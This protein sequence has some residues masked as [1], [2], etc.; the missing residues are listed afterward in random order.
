MRNDPL[1]ALPANLA[2]RRLSMRVALP[3]GP[4][5]RIG[6]VL[7][8]DAERLTLERRTG[9]VET[10]ERSR[11]HLA[12]LVPTVPRGRNPRHAPADQLSDLAHDPSLDAF[13]GPCW[14]ARL[15]DLVD[16][17]DDSG[18]R[19]LTPTSAA[20]GDSRGLVN[21]EWSAVRLAASADLVPLAAWAARRDAR[22]LVLTS[23]LAHDV[24]TSLGL[25]ELP[26]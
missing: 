18:V 15:C 7:A 3:D 11:I 19:R 4:A 5:D 1:Q 21:G 22:N 12:R 9:A 2:G 8:V 13:P 26:S 24:L 17:V 10:I 14:I 16:H 25:D 23:G 20:R 6:L